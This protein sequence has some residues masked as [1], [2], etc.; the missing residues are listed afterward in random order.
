MSEQKDIPQDNK[1]GVLKVILLFFVSLLLL[2]AVAAGILQIPA[3][4]T[5]AVRKLT[6]YLSDKTGF[7]TEIK[8]VNLRWFDAL[9]LKGVKVYD[10]QDSLMIGVQEIFVDFRFSQLLDKRQPALDEVVLDRPQVQMLKNTPDGGININE[11]IRNIRQLLPAKKK[12]PKTYTPFRIH[13]VVV[14]E[15]NFVFHDAAK[16][17]L[18]EYFDYNH[19]DLRGINGRIENFRL[20][21]DTLEF[22]VAELQA[23][24]PVYD[25]SVDNLQTFFRFTEHSMLFDDLL[26][27]AGKSVIR[28]SLHFSYQSTESLGYFVDSVKLAANFK[29]SKV[30][31]KDLAVFAPY[32][33][34]FDDTYKVSGRF[35]GTIANFDATRLQL[36][37]GDSYFEG[38]VSMDGL[39]NFD[40]TFIEAALKNS[41]LN[42]ADFKP[43][44]NDL[45]YENLQRLGDTRF[46]S[47][48]LG[49]PND[50]VANGDFYTQ[51]GFIRSDINLKLNTE[52]QEL[53]TYS[54]T[55]ALNDFWLGRLVKEADLGRVSMQGKV[56][57]QGF[58]MD[59]AKLRLDANIKKLTY[60][61][62]PYRNIKANGKLARSFF[63]GEVAIKDPN[64]QIAGLGSIDLRDKK[65]LIKVKARID[66]AF[67][68]PLNITGEE[69]FLSANV[70]LNISGLSLDELSGEAYLADLYMQYKNRDLSLDTLSF[71]SAIDSTQRQLIIES[72]RA[73]IYAAGNF[74]YTTL[75]RDV[76]RL[77]HEYALNF[78]NNS[79]EIEQY[80]DGKPRQQSFDK[81]K[82]DYVVKLKDINPVLHLL[83]PGI[84]ISK[85]T[86]VEG[87]F[88]GGYT[89][90]LSAN[91]F[92]DTIQY[93]DNTYYQ[94]QAELNTS[95]I[96]DSTDVL[97]MAFLQSAEQEMA[98]FAPTEQL[99]LEA[100]WDRDHIEFSGDIKQQS[101]DNAANLN[102]DVFFLED[103]T[104]LSFHESNIRI[105]ENNWQISKENRI[106][107]EEGNIRFE[108]FRVSNQDQDIFAE[109]VLSPDPDKQLDILIENFRL[110]NLN[111]ILEQGLA[112]AVNGHIQL[113]DVLDRPILNGKLNIDD[114][115]VEEFLVGDIAFDTRWDHKDEH[116]DIALE[117][118]RKDIEVLKAEGFYNPF[119]EENNLHIKATL[120]K[121]NL[122]LIEPFTTGIFSNIKGT[123]SGQVLITGTPRY[124]I[125]RGGG[126]VNNGQIKIDYTNTSYSF[127]GGFIFSENEIGFRDLQIRDTDNNPA[128]L[129][130]GIFHDGFDNFIINLKAR[131]DGTKVLNTSYEDNDLYYGTAYAQGDLEVLGP[132]NNLQ[133]IGSAR[134]AKGTKIYIP[135]DFGADFVQ[136]D[137]IHFVN[138]KDSL[139][140]AVAAEQNINLSG[141]K[142]DFDLEITP[143]AYCEIIF[144][145]RAG[146][147]I[148][149][150]GNGKLELQIDTEGEFTMFGNYEI[151]QG[152]YNFTLFNIITKEFI[153]DPGSTIRWMGD[154]YGGL[155][156]IQAHYRQSASLLPILSRSQ[157][158]EPTPQERRPYPVM[159]QMDLEGDL[160]SPAI[161][162]DIEV[163]DYPGVLYSDVQ[164]FHSQLMVDEQF[165]N[166]QVFNLIVLR[167]LAPSQSNALYAQGALGFGSQTAISSI[168][169]LLSNQF[170]ALATQIDEN[171]EIDL[172][173]SSSMD[174]DAINTFQ[175]RLSYTF[176]D[177]RLRITRDGSIAS[178]SEQQGATNLIGDWSFEY[179]LTPDGQ[180]KLKVYSR[181]NMNELGGPLRLNDYTQGVS[182]S[183]TKRFDTFK[184]L[185]Q[186]KKNKEEEKGPI[187]IQ[188]NSDAGLLR[189]EEIQEPE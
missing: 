170:S 42:P 8:R 176:L 150:R 163:R 154:P 71:F 158:A 16:D 38:S 66:T 43:Y 74:D 10:Q 69:F 92:I 53:S 189:E 153:I 101:S 140:P 40:E 82:I 4:Q 57:G 51:L 67:L 181:N 13:D 125:L 135:I 3:V 27:N 187:E 22:N 151:Q 87:S 123:A 177:G 2:L 36:Q 118:K 110:A 145:L 164:R 20:L 132:I 182:I 12:G 7:P 49:F 78:R 90:I 29:D 146:D 175:L 155:M 149:G 143:D 54:G 81:Y 103:K 23:S 117:A 129:D 111:P 179:L 130:G 35:N 165:L 89:S 152:A 65:E 144:D 77:Y 11:F 28:D 137:F 48:F 88:N 114:F 107:F 161:D 52:N 97:A 113:Q 120:N 183:Q 167:Q 70:D 47:N 64:L 24:A 172:D 17:S 63:E 39:P 84:S 105:L 1:K 80:Y 185:F 180:Y 173:V 72:D 30:Y 56:S 162:F 85:N 134:T 127:N 166:R 157:G 109:G 186:R 96:A 50:F 5:A 86:E 156:D 139:A 112:G 14:H 168:S 169:E 102:A 32:F 46:N 15:G 19:M 95:K 76:E 60:Q 93:K 171:L 106:V 21:A 174:A 122:D 25:F 45:L 9:S 18:E 124:P 73:D 100:I 160:L 119:K 61:G 59:E 128:L 44:L 121:T 115:M 138:K 126:N 6:A 75:A 62:Y 104:Q 178:R 159:V 31:A 98:G 58:S 26:L 37:L 142:L 68:Q 131:L 99:V 83:E 34:Q 141:I 184:E 41:R 94:L 55:L 148:R 136:Q 116:L 91:T 147:I 79:E 33:K 108:N 133:F 188:D